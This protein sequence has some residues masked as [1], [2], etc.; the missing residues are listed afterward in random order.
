MKQ[1]CTNYW[2]NPTT[3]QNVGAC[4]LYVSHI[5]E[6][7]RTQKIIS[8]FAFRNLLKLPWCDIF[9]RGYDVITSVTSPWRRCGAQAHE[10][11][12]WRPVQR[13]TQERPRPQQ[14]R[15]R[16]S[17]Q[18][19][20]ARTGR[21]RLLTKAPCTIIPGMIL[22]PSRKQFLSG[23]ETLLCKKVVSPNVPF[24]IVKTSLSGNL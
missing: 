12:R 13:P 22:L 18:R 2:L 11:R 15:G 5:C 19:E 3:F 14:P 9:T 16:S 1:F 20:A 6:H 10:R 23:Y 21:L 7:W 24:E 8:I 4:T 17:R